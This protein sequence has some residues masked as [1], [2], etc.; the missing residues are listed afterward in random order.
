MMEDNRFERDHPNTDEIEQSIINTVAAIAKGDVRIDASTQAGQEEL[1]RLSESIRAMV[2]SI[3]S[4]ETDEI[5][6]ASGLRPY[7]ESFKGRFPKG[8]LAKKSTGNLSPTFDELLIKGNKPE[9]AWQGA[10]R[11]V[12]D[13]NQS[14]VP[15]NGDSDFPLAMPI[16]LSGRIIGVAGLQRKENRPWSSNEINTLESIFEQLGLTL[17]NQRLFDQTQHALAETDLLYKASADINTAQLYNDILEILR[18]TTVLGM[19]THSIS[20][21]LF[22]SPWT[23]THRPDSLIPLAHWLD[24][25]QGTEDNNPIRIENWASAEEVLRPHQVTIIQDIPNDPRLNE[26]TRSK[27][28]GIF[29]ANMVAFVPLV[30]A[31]QWIGTLISVFQEVFDIDAGDIQRLGALAAQAAAAIQNIRLLEDTTRKATQLET[32]AEIAREASETLDANVLLNRAVNL[33]MERFGY[34]H[35]SIFQVERDTAVVRASTGEEG[36][37]LITE[38]HRVVIEEES[39]LIGQVCFRGE[40]MVVNNVTTSPAYLP[41]RLLPDTKAELGIP[42]KVGERVTGALDVHSRETNAFTP[43]EIAVLQTLADQIA[44][45][46]ENARSYQISQ[47]AVEEMREVD[48][49]KSQFLANMSHELRTP[50]NSIIGFSRVILKG[51]DGPINDLQQ[52]DLQAIYASGQHLLEMIN[53]ILDLSKIEAGK[54]ELAI[55]EIQIDELIKSVVSTAVG[56]VKEKPVS[57]HNNVPAHL[58]LVYADKTRIRQVLLNLLQNASKFTD[59]G[60]ISVDANV[61]NNEFGAPELVISVKD[62][63]I[64]I[65]LEDQEKLF[66]PFSQVDDSPT[67]KTGGSGLG[68]SISRR[69]VEMQGGRIWLESEVNKGSTFSFS[70]PV[71]SEPKTVP[72]VKEIPQGDKTIAAVDDDPKVIDLYHR[73]LKPHGYDIIAITDPETAIEEIKRIQPVGITMDIMMP[74]IDGWDV[75]KQLKE[76]PATS[77]IPIVVCSI[78]DNREKG[79]EL[80]ASNYLVKPILEDELVDAI[81]NISIKDSLATP[82]ILIIDDDPNALTLVEKVLSNQGQ[83][84][85]RF[86]EGGVKG[87][88]A[89]KEQAPDL[90]ILDLFMPELDGFA[91]LESIRTDAAFRDLPVVVLTSGDLGDAEIEIL[92]QEKQVILRKE[93]LAER[94]LLESLQRLLGE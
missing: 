26:E 90:V 70:V 37:T 75:L 3:K 68:L 59:E 73:Y 30:T 4:S 74:N 51:I 48:R 82:E 66:E 77:A 80:G 35:V 40:S 50:L 60:S 85:L 24:T 89:I 9:G 39:S 27:F 61:Q 53:S 81:R 33:I 69:L 64:G 57:I 79:F 44:I 17:E 42:L 22:N 16:R 23:E 58:P 13:Q 36:N 92:A 28:M 49:I 65:A 52:Q 19:H 8:Q 55:E 15:T 84:N 6:K 47:Q 67:R 76:D 11:E 46:V 18:K 93:S 14:A 25:P 78:L 7:I 21:N 83:Y 31:G 1:A 34:Y 88:S 54:M 20:I 38:Q 2:D 63:G 87:L 43:E 94:E 91:L 62:T 86:A 45:A 71:A 10:I 32:A 12:I 41:H 5:D 29:K 72:M 56:L